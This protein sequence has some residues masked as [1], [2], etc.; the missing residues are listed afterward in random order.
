MDGLQSG[1]K[2]HGHEKFLDYQ[3][4]AFPLVASKVK[5][6]KLLNQKEWKAFSQYN[7]LACHSKLE[8]TDE[9]FC[10]YSLANLLPKYGLWAKCSQRLEYSWDFNPDD[11]EI[12][13]FWA[14]IELS[15]QA[16]DNI[17]KWKKR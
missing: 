10:T 15:Q 7:S 12:N 9:G 8:D 13:K 14:F 1:E 6:G 16:E 5:K 3:R 17:F 2:I 11:K 4:W